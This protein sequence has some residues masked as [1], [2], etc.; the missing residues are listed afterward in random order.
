[1]KVYSRQYD[2][3]VL[4][5]AYFVLLFFKWPLS[6]KTSLLI[7]AKKLEILKL[8]NQDL[9]T[10]IIP[11]IHWPKNS[12]LGKSTPISRGAKPRGMGGILKIVLSEKWRINRPSKLASWDWQSYGT[13]E[14]LAIFLK[15]FK[16]VRCYSIFL[17]I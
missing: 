13:R 5:R 2:L 11:R 16:K 10:Y 17:T 9:L 14:N 6:K 15:L 1:M 3:G 4:T 8:L 12:Y 7:S